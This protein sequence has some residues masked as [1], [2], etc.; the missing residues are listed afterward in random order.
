M[1]SMNLNPVVRLGMVLGAL[2]CLLPVAG[3]AAEPEAP[4]FRAGAA[5]AN[6][7]PPLGC[8]IVGNFEVPKATYVHDDLHVRCLVLDDGATRLAIVLCD[9]LGID[10]HVFD[11]AKRRLQELTAIPPEHIL[12]AATHT[13][14]GPPARVSK[15]P[16]GYGE[17]TAYQQFM[18]DRIVDAVQCAINNLEP[19]QIGWGKGDEPDQVNNRRWHLSDPALMVSPFGAQDQVRMNPPR[20][21]AALVEP[22]GPTD[23]GIVFIAVRSLDGRP[24]ALLANYSLHYVGGVPGHI[25]ADYLA[26]SRTASSN[27]SAR[28]VRIRRSGHSVQRTSG[29]ST[30]SISGAHAQAGAVRTYT[31]RSRTLSRRKSSGSTDRRVHG[32]GEARGPLA[33]LTSGSENPTRPRCNGPTRSLPNPRPRWISSSGRTRTAR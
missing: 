33:R 22:A 1:N 21:H 15:C 32:P 28:T 8:D 27:C 9:N 26:R 5:R 10:Q 18:V 17:F 4:V 23:P 20:A 11:E 24:I 6:I 7:T 31:A 30:T 14:S 3:S 29:T 13:H 2:L 12:M 19:A 25:S 16:G